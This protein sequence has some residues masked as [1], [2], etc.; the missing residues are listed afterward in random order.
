[1]PSDPMMGQGSFDNA[2]NL[3][4]F[5]KLGYGFL[6][7]H[8]VSLST[9]IVRFSQKPDYYPDVR[10]NPA[11]VNFWPHMTGSRL[12]KKANI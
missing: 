6:E 9:E 2:E 7:G 5:G 4:L 10:A 3:N 8:R 1:M 11:A 12:R